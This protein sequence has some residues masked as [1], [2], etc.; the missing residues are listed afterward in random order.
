MVKAVFAHRELPF[1]YQKLNNF[2]G[3][4]H[5][6]HIFYSNRTT[7]IEINVCCLYLLFIYVTKVVIDVSRDNYLDILLCGRTRVA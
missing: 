7:V 4:P 6:L 2:R 5:L 3:C 1:L